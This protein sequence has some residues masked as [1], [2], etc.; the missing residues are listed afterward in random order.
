[1]KYRFWVEKLKKTPS[2]VDVFAGTSPATAFSIFPR[3]QRFQHANRKGHLRKMVTRG[4]REKLAFWSLLGLRYT[5]QLFRPI[6]QSPSDQ[7]WPKGDCEKPLAR[8]AAQ[9]A[10]RRKCWAWSGANV[11]E[12]RGFRDA[13]S[14][15]EAWVSWFRV[16]PLEKGEMRRNVAYVFRGS[17][18]GWLRWVQW[19]SK[20]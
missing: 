4:V 10:G 13:L 20:S 12:A 1:M 2:L 15:A 11:R 14:N 5:R 7:K 16:V 19:I 6:S 8:R 17:L 3:S 18:N 9:G